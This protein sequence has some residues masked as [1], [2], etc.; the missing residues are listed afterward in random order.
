M[1][2]KI[3]GAL[4]ILPTILFLATEILRLSKDSTTLSDAGIVVLERAAECKTVRVQE[5]TRAAHAMLL[6]SALASLVER[7]KSGQY[8]ELTNNTNVDN[9]RPVMHSQ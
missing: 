3:P 9:A 1:F 2:I 4:S 6:Q 8:I 7:V 5:Q